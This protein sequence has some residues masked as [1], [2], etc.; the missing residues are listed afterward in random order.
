MKLHSDTINSGSLLHLVVFSLLL[1]YRSTQYCTELQI[2]KQ[3]DI[4]CSTNPIR[5]CLK[6]FS[7][8]VNTPVIIRNGH[9]VI[10]SWMTF[11]ML[12]KVGV[13]L[14]FAQDTKVLL[15]PGFKP[16]TICLQTQPLNNE[17]TWDA[18]D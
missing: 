8:S 17:A 7:L 10:I 1:T 2:G 18:D 9:G 15:A 4:I 3:S 14:V 13:F 5:L 16:V 12:K 6:T 11:I